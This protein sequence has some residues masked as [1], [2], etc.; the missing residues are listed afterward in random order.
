V[1]FCVYYVF[2]LVSVPIIMREKDYMDCKDW[3]DSKGNHGRYWRKGRMLKF[4]FHFKKEN[5]FVK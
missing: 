2:V 1:C 5:I 4:Y 3:G